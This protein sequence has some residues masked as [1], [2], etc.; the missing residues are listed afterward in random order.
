MSEQ[1]WAKQLKT[2]KVKSRIPLA[3][4]EKNLKDRMAFQKTLL[5]EAITENNTQAVKTCFTSLVELRANLL[6]LHLQKRK[7]QGEYLSDKVLQE[8]AYSFTKE[9]INL[10]KA[11]NISL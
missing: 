10:A 11:L 8:E 2:Q 5:R 9:S 1:L 3:T 7:E 4:Q 6:F